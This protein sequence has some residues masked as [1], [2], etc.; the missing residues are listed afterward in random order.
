MRRLSEQHVL[1][2]TQMRQEAEF[3]MDDM[4]SARDRIVRI[5]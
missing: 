1:G 4:D 5:G 3:L 2:D